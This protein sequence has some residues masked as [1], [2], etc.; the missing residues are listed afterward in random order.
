VVVSIIIF[1]AGWLASC[2]LG[3]VDDDVDTLAC[4][5]VLIAVNC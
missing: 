1:L 5:A 3:M 4:V 2:L